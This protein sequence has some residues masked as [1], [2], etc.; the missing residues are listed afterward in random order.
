MIYSAPCFL[1]SMMHKRDIVP[2][3]Y[4][5]LLCSFSWLCNIPLHGWEYHTLHLTTSL[6]IGLLVVSDL[7][8]AFCCTL[9]YVPTTIMANL[10]INHRGILKRCQQR[11]ECV[12]D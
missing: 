5:K 12:K 9:F 7:V 2:C 1:C 11:N 10:N 8:F 3:H 4:E 6:L